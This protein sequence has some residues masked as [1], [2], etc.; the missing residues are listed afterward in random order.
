MT[1]LDDALID[2]LAHAECPRAY[3]FE[4]K[5]MAQEILE[6][7]NKERAVAQQS[8]TGYTGQPWPPGTYP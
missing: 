3:G 2:R 5:A 6:F 8:T 7:R 1:R 4:V